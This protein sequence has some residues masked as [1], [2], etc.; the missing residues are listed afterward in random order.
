MT[1]YNPGDEVKF[2]NEKGGGTVIRMIDSRMVL[3]AIEDG[4]EIPVLVNDIVIVNKQQAKTRSG[5]DVEA[6]KREAEAQAAEED[7]ARKTGLRRFA[8]NPEAEGIYLAFVPHEQQWILTGLMDVVLVNHTPATLLYS[9]TLSGEDGFINAD[10]GQ[11]E[12]SSK[13]VI[14]TISRDDINHWIKGVVQGIL[15]LEQSSNVYQPL[16]AP[17]DIKPSRFYKEGSYA[18]SG[19]LG[20]KVIMLTLNTLNVLKMSG[21]LQ[22]ALKHETVKSEP[23]KQIVKEKALIDKHRS[24]AGEAVIDLH[25]GELIDNIAGLSSRDMFNIQMDYFKKTLDSAMRNDYV[26]VTY[27]HGVGNGVLKNAIVQA[28]NDFEEVGQRMASMQKF[29]VGAIDILIKGLE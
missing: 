25:I 10:Y 23:L 8:K 27:I 2:L 16:Y 1:K 5:V 4:F 11:A 7:K 28:L 19:I 18:M 13:V 14:E 15:I 22:A 20:D 26:K 3:V 21:D 29:G 6:I 24:A 9:L 17:F 12:A